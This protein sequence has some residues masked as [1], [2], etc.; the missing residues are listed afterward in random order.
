MIFS[1][2]AI[3]R[4]LYKKLDAKQSIGQCNC[5]VCARACG[6]CAMLS[7]LYL[8]LHSREGAY[9]IALNSNRIINV[10]FIVQNINLTKAIFYK[11]AGKQVQRLRKRDAH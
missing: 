3:Q 2:K 5:A 7:S 6:A 9:K 1:T 8:L 10:L 4:G 11:I